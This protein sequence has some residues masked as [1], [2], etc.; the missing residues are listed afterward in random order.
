MFKYIFTL[1][2]LNLSLIF[3]ATPNPQ[4]MPPRQDRLDSSSPYAQSMLAKPRQILSTLVSDPQNVQLILSS[5]P[6]FG[7]E[8]VPPGVFSN[9]PGLII[10][11]GALAPNQNQ[12]EL[13]F[14]IAHELGHIHYR[15]MQNMDARMDKIFN[16]PPIGI[17]GTTFNIFMQKI[18]ERQADLYGQ[19]LYKLAGYDMSFFRN[20]SAYIQTQSAYHGKSKHSSLSMSDSHFSMQD[21]FKLLAQL[22]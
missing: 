13:R 5:N 18:E 22:S 11:Q 4:Q 14:M 17:S 3:A 12:N 7:G 1:V 19:H 10:Y 21:R 9:K 2:I 8:A 16:G 15:H 6:N 20:Q